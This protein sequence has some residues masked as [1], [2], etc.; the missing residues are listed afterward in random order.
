MSIHSEI[1]RHLASSSIQECIRALADKFPES[2]RVHC[3]V[4]IRLEAKGPL[5]AALKYYE[6]LL[7]D[8]ESNAVCYL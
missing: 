1:S 5:E 7:A 3:L 6:D 4:G 8:D 2:P